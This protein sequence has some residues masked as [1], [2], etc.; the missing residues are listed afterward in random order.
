MQLDL[1]SHHHKVL[2]V[3][4][5]LTGEPIAKHEFGIYGHQVAKYEL[6]VQFSML[7][8]YMQQ[9]YIRKHQLRFEFV[10]KPTSSELHKTCAKFWHGLMRKKYK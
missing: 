1:L 10:F 4:A 8:M 7:E 2:E 5:L 6:E 3:E 9:D